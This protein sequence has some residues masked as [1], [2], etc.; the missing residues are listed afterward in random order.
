[1]THL[2]YFRLLTIFFFNFLGK[3]DFLMLCG[4][5]V[6]NPGPQ[7]NSGQSFSIRHWNLNSIAAQNFSRISLV[8]A[9]NAIHTYGI[10]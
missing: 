4:N 10:I 1:M 3:F 2:F 8:K 6:P 9:Y 7:S 5:I